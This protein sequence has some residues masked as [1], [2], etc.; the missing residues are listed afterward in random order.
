MEFYTFFS[1]EETQ[2]INILYHIFTLKHFV[3]FAFKR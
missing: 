2:Y 1:F 3:K